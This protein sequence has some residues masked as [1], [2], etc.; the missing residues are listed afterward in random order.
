MLIFRI[1]GS[2]LYFNVEHVRAVACR[3]ISATPN[4]RLVVCDL[5]NSPVVDVAGAQMLV[6][7]N[8]DLV[9][10]GIAMRVVEA[11]AKARD[12]LRAE[13]VE[14]RVGYLGRHSPLDSV[15][16]EFELSSQPENDHSG[17]ERGG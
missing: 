2:L 15:I 5:S 3:R 8:Q 14:D 10:Q 17:S 16:Q 12:L 13:G 1:E 6:R 9:A 4:L 7:L 11:H